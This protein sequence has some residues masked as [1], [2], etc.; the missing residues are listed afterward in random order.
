MKNLVK[1]AKIA[2]K[3][4]INLTPIIKENLILEIAKEINLAKDEILKANEK[5]LEFAKE[6]NLSSAMFE[7]LKLDEKKLNTIS[8]SLKD[9]AKLKD[10]IGKVLDGWVNYAG[11]KFN[12]VSI[13]IGVVCIIYESRPNV[14]TEVASLC[15][16]SS[17][18][19]V[20]K[21]G[22]ESKNSN[23][24]L[25]KCIHK[26]LDKFNIDRSVVTYLSDFTHE[27]TAKL[28]KLDKFIDVIVPRGSSNLVKFISENSTIPVIKHDKGMCHIFVDKSTKL[29]M[30]LKICENAKFNNPSACN[31][32]ETILV[33]EDIA[34]EF[35]PALGIKFTALGAKIY[36]C[37]KS[38]KFL[39]SNF[40]LANKESYDTEYLGLALNLKIVKDVNEA[41]EHIKEFGSDHSE[42]ILS[43]NSINIEIFMNELDSACLYVNASTRFSDG[44]EFGFGAEVGISTNKLH[45]RGPMG[46]EGLTTYKYKIVGNGQIRE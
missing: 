35:I 43:Q 11:L 3:E 29:D 40:E 26:A 24:A 10:P 31:A 14:T 20:L 7:R 16:K 30:A 27:D 9:T 39:N 23:L 21:G 42:A 18:S 34:S 28:I 44:Y 19:C 37:K 13:P 41:V 45:V 6:K 46:L 15:L 1:K 33:H 12:K 25:V 32:V 17:N 22:S 36:S 5:D 38:A 2:Q 4:L 8:A